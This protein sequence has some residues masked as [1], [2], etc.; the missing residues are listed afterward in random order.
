MPRCSRGFAFRRMGFKRTA[1]LNR[2]IAPIHILPDLLCMVAIVVS[3][4]HE[5]VLQIVYMSFNEQ[6]EV[7]IA[8]LYPFRLVVRLD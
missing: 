3:L 2:V 5:D 1:R 6:I 7:R 8:S 4:A